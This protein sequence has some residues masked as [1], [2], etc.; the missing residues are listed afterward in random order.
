MKA[1]NILPVA[2]QKYIGDRSYTLNEV[3]MSDSRGICFEDMVLKMERQHEE[4]DNEYRM[5]QWLH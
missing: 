1:L 2:I 5:M 3:G 4:A